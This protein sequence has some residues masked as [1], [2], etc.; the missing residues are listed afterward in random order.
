M[1][2]WHIQTLLVMV[3]KIS[4]FKH[5]EETNWIDSPHELTEFKKKWA[6]GLFLIPQRIEV[7]GL[8]KTIRGWSDDHWESF[9][10]H[11]LEIYGP[12]PG[13]WWL[14]PW[15]G[16]KPWRMLED[17]VLD[18]SGCYG[19]WAIW[20]GVPW[21]VAVPIESS[22]FCWWILTHFPMWPTRANSDLDRHELELCHFLPNDIT[23]GFL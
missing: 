21:E 3:D 14:A 15:L 5:E 9:G 19:K 6:K 11:G 1:S 22:G 4:S 20:L 2:Y 8:H 12:G 18:A 16:E 17:T 13:G 7:S 23:G 10:F